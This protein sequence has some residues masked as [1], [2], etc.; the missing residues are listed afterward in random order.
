[1][2]VPLHFLDIVSKGHKIFLAYVY[3][4]TIKFKGIAKHLKTSAS[5]KRYSRKMIKL[6]LA[7]IFRHIF[8]SRPVKIMQNM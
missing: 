1:M 8:D 2:I 4:L 7:I 6:E 3:T 5:K